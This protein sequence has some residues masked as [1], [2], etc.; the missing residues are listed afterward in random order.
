METLLKCRKFEVRREV[1]TGTDGASHTRE[2]VIHPGAVVVL[3]LP[4]AD[5]CLM[6]RQLR[7]AI[8]Q[9]IWEL[10]AGTLDIAGEPPE[11][12]A[13]REL[14]EEAGVRAGKLTRL[15]GFY[16]SPGIM[17]EKI[18]AFVAEDLRPGRQALG[19]TEQIHEVKRLP[20]VDA[21]KMAMDGRI[22]DAKTIITLMVWDAQRRRNG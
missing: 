20:I 8:G 21:M 13:S 2:Y 12:A 14:E 16:P 15:C 4:D 9:E 7:P 10:P 17:S 5:H 1:V 19:P 6:L 18:I 3:A 11:V 22:V